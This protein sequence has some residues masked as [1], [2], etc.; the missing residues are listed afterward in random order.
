MII[1]MMIKIFAQEALLTEMVSRAILKKNRSFSR[2]VT[3]LPVGHIGVPLSI[4]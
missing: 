1:M 4:A 2:D 3:S